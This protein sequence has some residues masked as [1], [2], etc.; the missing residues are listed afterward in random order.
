MAEKRVDSSG[1]SSCIQRET[2]ARAHTKRKQ[3]HLLALHSYSLFL[4][5]VHS[6]TA[7]VR[8]KNNGKREEGVA[9][10]KISFT[11][12][13]FCSMLIGAFKCHVDLQRRQQQR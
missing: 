12:F 3:R 4:S 6:A 11:L 9:S 10:E 2:R 7:A 5:D 1:S 8:Q 13:L